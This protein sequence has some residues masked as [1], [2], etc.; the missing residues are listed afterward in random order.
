MSK[1]K[2]KRAW[3]EQPKLSNIAEMDEW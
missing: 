1:E 3:T 2:T